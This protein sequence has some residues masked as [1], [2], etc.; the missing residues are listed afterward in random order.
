MPI[1][2][3]KLSAQTF[4]SGTG[5]VALC[6]LLSLIK[7]AGKPNDMPR[8]FSHP[9]PPA[10]P[11]TMTGSRRQTGNPSHGQDRRLNLPSRRLT[12]PQEGSAP[13]AGRPLSGYPRR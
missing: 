3:N 11:L 9:R 4:P 7:R 1:F 6:N 10:G 2:T 12:G 13:A 8:L 5:I